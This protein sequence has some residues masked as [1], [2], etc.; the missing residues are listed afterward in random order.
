MIDDGERRET[1]CSLAFWLVVLAAAAAAGAPGCLGAT[2][3]TSLW[4]GGLGMSGAGMGRD[5]AGSIIIR[6]KVFSS[7]MMME[8]GQ[9]RLKRRSHYLLYSRRGHTGLSM[10]VGPLGMMGE[11]KASGEGVRTRPGSPGAA[12]VVCSRHFLASLASS[13][14]RGGEARARRPMAWP[15]TPI[16][17]LPCTPRTIPPPTTKT[18]AFVCTPLPA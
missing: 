1:S 11:G 6:Q 5:K 15:Q 2:L 10:M 8:G 17:I 12:V 14:S 16:T 3:R 7:S 18:G 9:A 4:L 13:K